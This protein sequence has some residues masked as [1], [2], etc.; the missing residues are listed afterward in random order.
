MPRRKDNVMNNDILISEVGSVTIDIDEYRELVRR[1]AYL[2]VIMS[3]AHDPKAFILT[4][5]SCV[6]SDLLAGRVCDEEPKDTHDSESGEA[7]A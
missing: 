6:I 7:D 1:S 2:D 5:I 4:D 3:F